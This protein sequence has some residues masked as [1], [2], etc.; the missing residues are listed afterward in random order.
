MSFNGKLY[1][2]EYVHLKGN[3]L[4]VKL[5]GVD[6]IVDSSMVDCEYTVLDIPDVNVRKTQ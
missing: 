1:F 4:L 6:T 3:T 2:V 5:N